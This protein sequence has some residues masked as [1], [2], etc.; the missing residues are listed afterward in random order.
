MVRRRRRST[1]PKAGQAR[2]RFDQPSVVVLGPY[3]QLLSNLAIA[4]LVVEEL[5]GV[6]LEEH[7]VAESGPLDLTQ[8]LGCRIANGGDPRQVVV[9]DQHLQGPLSEQDRVVIPLTELHLR[10]LMELESLCLQLV[11]EGQQ[12]AGEREELQSET[13]GR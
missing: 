10:A 1:P 12:G 4:M 9:L 7:E 8:R 6:E 3:P 11:I 2:F 5:P 13:E